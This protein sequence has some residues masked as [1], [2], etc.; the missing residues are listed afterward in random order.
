MTI[1]ESIRKNKF[2]PRKPH[3]KDE[4]FFHMGIWWNISKMYEFLRSVDREPIVYK[5]E[6]LKHANDFIDLDTEYALATDT[7]RPGIMIQFTEEHILLVDGHHRVHRVQVEAIQHFSCYY[8]S[9]HEQKHFITDTDSYKKLIA[10]QKMSRKSA[11]S[12]V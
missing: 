4:Q 2:I 8:L 7:D 3:Y 1:E 5:L 10:V 6:Q 9:L 12:A 11:I